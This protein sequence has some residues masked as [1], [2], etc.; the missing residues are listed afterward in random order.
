MPNGAIGQSDGAATHRV[1]DVLRAQQTTMGP[2]KN[3]IDNFLI[4]NQMATQHR[5][6][7]TCFFAPDLS[8]GL[9]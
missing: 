8:A 9:N 6:A 4:L 7:L 5:G 1:M 2:I 3:T